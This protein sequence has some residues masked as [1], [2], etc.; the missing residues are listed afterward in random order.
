VAT[1]VAAPATTP[2]APVVA[3]AA[4]VQTVTQ[5]LDDWAASWRAK[6]VERYL[7]FYSKSFAPARSTHAKWAQERRRLVGKEGP[8]DL[9]I[10]GVKSSAQGDAVQTAF[11]QTYASANFKDQTAKLLTWRQEANQW[12]IVKE[13]NR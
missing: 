12:V 8:I 10:E 11:T 13:S 1:P 5:R 7:S 6:D 9:K 4:A 3:D 2:A